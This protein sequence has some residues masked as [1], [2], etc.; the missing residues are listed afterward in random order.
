MKFTTHRATYIARRIKARFTGRTNLHFLHIRK[1]GGTSLKNALKP[2]LM[3]E[4][5]ML[6]LR[7]HYTRLQDIP[8]RDEVMFVTRDPIS[9]FISGFGSRLR[10]ALPSRFVPW[11]EDEAVAFSRFAT[12]NALALALAPDHPQHAE[13]LHAMDSISHIKYTYWD[14]FRDEELM[15]KRWHSILFIGRLESFHDDFEQLKSAIGLPESVVLPSDEKSSNRSDTD[16]GSRPVLEPTAIENLKRW[17][18][19]D[20]DFLRLCD[21]WRIQQGGPIRTK[22]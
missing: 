5:W 21:E 3:T 2:H 14:W 10:Q 20:Y 6:F 11:S 17:Y 12:P 8:A 1:T 4:G 9:R 16:A 19:R 13:A 7:Q 22:I 15:R 18:Q